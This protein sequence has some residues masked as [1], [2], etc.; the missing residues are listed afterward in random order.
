MHKLTE[1]MTLSTKPTMDGRES[2]WLAFMQE[3]SRRG[4]GG[5]PE[6][7]RVWKE[8]HWKALL[9]LGSRLRK[10]CC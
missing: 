5:V 9:T 8:K 3:L 2:S 10:C 1:G 4:D 7:A 6:G